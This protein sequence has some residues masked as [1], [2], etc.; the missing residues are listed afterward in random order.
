MAALLLPAAGF[1]ANG[2]VSFIEGSATRTAEKGGKVALK[3]KSE[4]L[5]GDLIETQGSGR[6]EL[7][8]PDKSVVRL[9]PSSKLKLDKT[10][11]SDDGRTFKAKL[12][13]GSIWS[14]V[15]SVFG[16]DKSFEIKTDRAVAGVRGTVFR[17]DADKTSAVMVKVYA[18]TVAVA[19]G[20]IPQAGGAP[21]KKERVQVPGPQPVSKKQ[22]E[23]LV[24][25][26]MM[27]KVAA[28]GEVTEPEKFA[29]ADELKDAWAAWNKQRDEL[30]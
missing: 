3:D 30:P 25:A 19:G 26:M 12:M 5:Q 2:Q 24:T 10:S 21:E 22:W 20:P 4:V 9:G 29:E 1:A 7:T 6:L 14:K 23:K 18:G 27:V 15:S 16:S 28:N 13:L 8:M 17:L 11:F